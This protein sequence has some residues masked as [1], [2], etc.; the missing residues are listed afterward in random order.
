MDD[1]RVSWDILIQDLPGDVARL[2]D[3]PDDFRP[4]TLG[5]RAELI[6]QIIAVAPT[7]DFSDPSWGELV[8]P[9]FVIEF[10]MGRE[11]VTDSV[12]LH[13]RGGGEAADFVATLLQHLGRR[14]VDCSEG[15]FFAEADGSASFAR[16]QAYRDK[17]LDR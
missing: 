15:E 11:V 10:S 8:T 3:I 13:V 12:M 6:S 14:A 9:E 5:D 7:A 2:Q 4:G 17:V 16:W 1:G